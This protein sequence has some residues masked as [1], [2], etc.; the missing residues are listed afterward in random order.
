MLKRVVGEEL[1]RGDAV[2][3]EGSSETESPRVIVNHTNGSG[4]SNSGV[5]RV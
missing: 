3:G 4:Q 2:V 1:G 5:T